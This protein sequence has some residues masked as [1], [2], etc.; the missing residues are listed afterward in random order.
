MV[1]KTCARG[2]FSCGRRWTF[3]KAIQKS[4]FYSKKYGDGHLILLD[5]SSCTHS[6][7]YPDDLDK[8]WT[9]QPILVV[10]DTG[11]DSVP[12]RLPE[13]YGLRLETAQLHGGRSWGEY[14]P[15]STWP[16]GLLWWITE[17]LLLSVDCK[18]TERHCHA[19]AQHTVLRK[20]DCMPAHFMTA[21]QFRLKHK[22]FSFVDWRW[23]GWR[24]HKDYLNKYWLMPCWW[25]GSKGLL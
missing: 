25:M 15:D 22:T 11:C 18:R 3:K 5:T 9:T 24:K 7:V 13:Q 2:A 23:K 4:V 10:C 12:A 17:E 1:W 6:A 14:T 21:W 19:V 8:C 16:P 20:T